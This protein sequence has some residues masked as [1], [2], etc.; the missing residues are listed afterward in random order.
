MDPYIRPV[1]FWENLERPWMRYNAGT[2]VERLQ[3][4][5]SH[6]LRA[7]SR[8]Q[9]ESLRPAGHSTR[10]FSK[11]RWQTPRLEFLPRIFR[12]PLFRQRTLS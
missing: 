8:D 1:A 2:Q 12:P 6:L 7:A 4:Y 11:D 9:P 3:D 10:K 5:Y